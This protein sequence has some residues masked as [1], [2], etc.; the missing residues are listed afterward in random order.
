MNG[1]ENKVIKFRVSDVR[2]DFPR[3]LYENTIKEGNG[4]HLEFRG[5]TNN[6]FCSGL[7]FDMS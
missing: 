4:A 5:T 2:W 3:E 1:F 7:F 6:C